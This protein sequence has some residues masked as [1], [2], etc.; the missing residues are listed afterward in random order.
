M[1]LSDTACR[2]A[3]AKDKTYKKADGGGLY[4]EI[5]PSGGKYW[6]MK[7]R[8][9]G[10][11][12]RLSFGVYPIVTLAEAREEREK[13]KKLLAKDI[14]PSA[15]KKSQKR[16]TILQSQNTFKAVAL[17]WHENQIPRWSEKHTESVLRKLHTDIFPYI[18]ERP[19]TEIDAP[20]I[21]D[22][23]RKIEKRGAIDMAHRA[24]QICGQV[25][26][27]GIATGRGKRDHAA[28]LKDALVTVKTRHFSALSIE[29][30]P[31]FLQKL[32][33]NETRLFPST[34]RAIKLLML[35]FVRTTELIHATWEEIDLDKAIWAIPA[36][37]MKMRKPH[38]VPLSKQMVALLIEQKEEVQHLNT[39]WV[40]P[41]PI[42]P[43]QPIS[44]NTILVAIK[45]MGYGGRMTGHGF[46][47]LARTTIR[48]NLGYDADVIERQ[49][50]HGKRNKVAAAYDRAQF[51]AKRKIMMQEWSDFLDRTACSGNIITTDK[52]G[53]QYEATR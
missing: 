31:A 26:R 47:A 1:K 19:I 4:L 45:R 36:E 32:E 18:G 5:L 23:L 16:K 7:Y 50:A 27:Y 3:K 46:R 29:E 53:A 39:N 9:A 34:R 25:F 2:T 28:D 20:E 14:D 11:E 8:F 15:H 44:N 30:M 37:R 13:A 43:R 22:V 52:F 51:L 24:R 21:L 6:R 35:S 33:R 42:K 40:F 10:K 12:K 49:L 41:S 48:E 38:L 17:E